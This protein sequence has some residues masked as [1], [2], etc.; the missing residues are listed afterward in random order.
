M[1]LFT[2]VQHNLS[3]IYTHLYNLLNNILAAFRLA[4]FFFGNTDSRKIKN[5]F[6]SDCS[7]RSKIE[8][9]Y[10]NIS[11]WWSKRHVKLC[12]IH[13][14]KSMKSLNLAAIKSRLSKPTQLA[15]LISQLAIRPFTNFILHNLAF[16][17]IYF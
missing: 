10:K 11:K 17:F 3:Y 6:D 7:T 4:T 13:E 12:D 2:K 5:Y 8:E 16:H 14:L 15:M 1:Q 9:K